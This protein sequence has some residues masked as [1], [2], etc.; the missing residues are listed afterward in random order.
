LSHENSKK[1]PCWGCKSTSVIRWGK[2]K[3]KQRFKCKNCGLLFS[4]DNRGVKSANRFIWFKEWVIGR[5]TILRISRESKYSER[6]LK[7]YFHSYLSVPPI[8]SVRPSE[9]VNLLIDGTYFRKDLCLVLYRDDKIKYTQLYR[10]TDGEWFEEIKEDLTNL[11]ALGVQ[12]E[13]ITCDGHKSLLKAIKKVCRHV[14]VQRCTIHVQRMC[15]IWLTRRPQSLA[16]F[17][18]RRIISQLH[19][20]KTREDWGYWIVG[21]IKWQQKHAHFLNEKSINLETGRYWYKHKMLRRSFTV[22]RRA[23]PD[24]FYYL[25]HPQIPKSTNGLESFFGHLKNH[26]QI[27]RG[28]SKEH[29]KNFIKWYLFFKNQK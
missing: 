3:G 19:K 25:D 24:M 2:Q 6:S 1:K 20:I 27:H 13:S 11:L 21:L 26:I 14:I 15:L 9:K 4:R 10:I 18:L 22:I 5:Q 17:E 8:L 29:K 28:L 16:G 12:I 7:R 23:L